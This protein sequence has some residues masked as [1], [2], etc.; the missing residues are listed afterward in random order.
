MGCHAGEHR[1]RCLGAD[2]SGV[3]P[4]TQHGRGHDRTETK[5]LEQVRRQERTMATIASWC[6]TASIVNARKRRARDRNARTVVVVSTSQEECTRMLAAVASMPGSFCPRNRARTGSGAAITRLNI[7]CCASVAAST[8]ERRAASS[9]DSAC[10]S[11]PLRGVP[12]AVAAD[13]ANSSDRAGA[14]NHERTSRTKGRVASHSKGHT[15][16]HQPTAQH[17]QAAK[18]PHSHATAYERGSTE[19]DDDRQSPIS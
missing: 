3:G 7:C 19:R 8:A 17:H 10:R 18:D 11:P 13:Q 6:S 14:S 1:E 16:G 2:P 5:L 4:G 12:S 9:T 15:R